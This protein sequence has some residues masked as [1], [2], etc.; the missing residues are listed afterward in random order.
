MRQARYLRVKLEAR[1]A[2]RLQELQ[3]PFLKLAYVCHAD[4]AAEC[5]EAP[6][7]CRVDH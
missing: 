5:P 4:R 2:L 1:L 6:I 7:F 3:L